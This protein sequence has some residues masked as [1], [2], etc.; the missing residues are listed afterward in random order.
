MRCRLHSPF[1]SNERIL[2][3]HHGSHSTRF[4]KVQVVVSFVAKNIYC[5]S[6]FKD[7]NTNKV[8]NSSL[9]PGTSASRALCS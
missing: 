4:E 3:S 1:F 5:E 6:I 9:L 7:P 8:A 2:V